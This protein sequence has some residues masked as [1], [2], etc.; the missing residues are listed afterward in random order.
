[1]ESTANQGHT[2][3]VDCMMVIKVTEEKEACFISIQ[4]SNSDIQNSWSGAPH[5]SCLDRQGSCL[6]R[7]CFVKFVC[8]LFTTVIDKRRET[9]GTMIDP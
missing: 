5:A 1:M 3:I 6:D 8:S 7:L 9:R 2:V 4:E